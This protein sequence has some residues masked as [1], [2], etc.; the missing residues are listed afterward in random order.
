MVEIRINFLPVFHILFCSFFFFLASFPRLCFHPS[1][2]I[3][4]VLLREKFISSSHCKMV[5]FSCEVCNDTV[6]KKKL[7]QH[8]QR[9]HGAYFTCID[10]ST[11]FSGN[12][13]KSHTQCISEAE[14][15]EKALYKGKKG[16]QAKQEVAKPQQKEEQKEPKKETEAKEEKKE[17][18]QK[19]KKKDKIDLSKYGT[20]SL[21]KIVKSIAKDSKKDKKEVLQ[22]LKVKEE[23]GQLVLTL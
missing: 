7:D 20:G 1:L 23:N 8:K 6:I 2:S 18:K 10:C 16:K 5:S 22:N 11:T 15:Y 12:D 21:Y 17:K 19:D 14:K 4:T 3:A 9:C 13:Y